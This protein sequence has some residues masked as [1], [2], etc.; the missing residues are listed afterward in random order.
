M[1][2]HDDIGKNTQ[3]II[4]DAIIQAV[5]D[6]LTGNIPDKYRQSVDNGIGNEVDADAFGDVLFFH[7]G[8]I[9]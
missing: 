9:P 3:I 6:E 2:G 5:N 4:G 1:I 8:M 7:D